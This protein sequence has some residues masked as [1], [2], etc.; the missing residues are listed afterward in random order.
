MNNKIQSSEQVNAGQYKR[1][2]KRKLQRSKNR[3]D[4]TLHLQYIS[5]K[6]STDKNEYEFRDR[7]KK[8]KCF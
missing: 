6:I 3:N 4:D 8:V 2:K 5:Y 1:M 7:N